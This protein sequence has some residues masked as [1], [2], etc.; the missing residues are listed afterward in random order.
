MLTCPTPDVKGD[1]AWSA[2]RA[3]TILGFGVPCVDSGPRIRERKLAKFIRWGPALL[4]TVR[5]AT[6]WFWKF[7]IQ[8]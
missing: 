5:L 7:S 3:G 1:P 2:E 6:R 8:R 4:G